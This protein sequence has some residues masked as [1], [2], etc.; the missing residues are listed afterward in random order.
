[1][2]DAGTTVRPNDGLGLGLGVVLV[3]GLAAIQSDINHTSL[4]SPTYWR[5]AN[6]RAITLR[7]TSARDESQWF[8]NTA[9][10]T[11]LVSDHP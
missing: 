3:G 4:A 5:R 2:A 11:W 6:E 10:A 8:I 1:M 9:C 7:V